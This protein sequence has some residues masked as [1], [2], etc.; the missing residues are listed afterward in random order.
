MQT[1]TSFI[2]ATTTMLMAMLLAVGTPAMAQ[3]VS[4]TTK[5]KLSPFAGT[6]LSTDKGN[7]FLSKLVVEDICRQVVTKPVA[8]NNPWAG[9]LGH[10]KKTVYRE[11]IVEPSSSCSTVD[12]GWGRSRAQVDKN[13]HLKAQYR[14]FWSQRFLRLKRQDQDLLVYWRIEYIGRK[15]PDQTG[16]TRMIRAQ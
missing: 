9:S 7:P 16:E 4:E 2:L 15:K 5:C 12:C 3:Q 8:R 11:L 1:C 13:G 6:W 14:L 10:E